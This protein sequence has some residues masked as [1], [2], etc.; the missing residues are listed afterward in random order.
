MNELEMS[1]TSQMVC[2]VPLSRGMIGRDGNVRF[3][4]DVMKV[5]EGV[6]TTKDDSN[7]D[8]DGDVVLVKLKS[9]PIRVR[10]A[11]MEVHLPPRRDIDNMLGGRDGE[12]VFGVS[13]RGCATKDRNDPTQYLLDEMDEDEEESDDEQLNAQ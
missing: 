13:K 8:D 10:G 9:M 1:S 3:R 11:V 4:I 6:T 12:I 5:L 2:D 7:G